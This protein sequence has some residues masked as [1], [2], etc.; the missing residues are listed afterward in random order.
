MVLALT[1]HPRAR[2]N[3]R[4]ASRRGSPF[5]GRPDASRTQ[6]VDDVHG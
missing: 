4:R 2:R 1:H 5:E 3:L 6:E